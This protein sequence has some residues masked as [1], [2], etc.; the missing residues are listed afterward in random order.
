MDYKSWKNLSSNSISSH[1]LLGL[2]LSPWGFCSRGSLNFTATVGSWKLILFRPQ[3]PLQSQHWGTFHK[4]K[5]NSLLGRFWQSKYIIYQYVGHNVNPSFYSHILSW[6]SSEVGCQGRLCQ[7][8]QT[9][10]VAENL[11]SL[12]WWGERA[13]RT[14]NVP[15]YWFLLSGPE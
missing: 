12:F 1:K 8:L 3:S 6:Y 13:S 2:N 11:Q 14:G 10:F 15:S 7:K 5:I 9:L 4:Q